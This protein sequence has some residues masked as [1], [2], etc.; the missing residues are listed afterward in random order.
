MRRTLRGLQVLLESCARHLPVAAS[1]SPSA[2]PD[3]PLIHVLNP[4][5]CDESAFTGP[6]RARAKAVCRSAR[7]VPI[8]SESICAT[9]A[10][11]SPQSLAPTLLR[12]T[13]HAR[14]ML[15]MLPAARYAE[16][17]TLHAA[18]R[19]LHAARISSAACWSGARTPA[20]QVSGFSPRL[21]AGRP[22][23]PHSVLPSEWRRTCRHMPLNASCGRDRSG[24]MRRSS[25][26][27]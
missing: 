18:S 26:Y 23:R 20:V 24:R 11:C 25:L 21:T 16:H 15:C 6:R 17:P 3:F 4:T 7:R 19:T 27:E 13:L 8:L 9:S 10:L 22:P 14:C 5:P 12:Y 2:L 1:R